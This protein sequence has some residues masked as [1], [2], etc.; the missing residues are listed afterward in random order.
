MMEDA[1]DLAQSVRMF[2]RL[3]EHDN[4]GWISWKRLLDTAMCLEVH[5]MTLFPGL[6]DASYGM[7][8]REVGRGAGS[9]LAQANG[10]GMLR[11]SR[12]FL[13]PTHT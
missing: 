8:D 10:E 3:P 13:P 6:T 4:H 2:L 11:S 5:N 1:R 12:P 9:L 7:I